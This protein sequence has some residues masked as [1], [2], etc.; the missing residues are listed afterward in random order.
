VLIFRQGL[1]LNNRQWE[2]EAEF[3]VDFD[4]HR[5]NAGR[6]DLESTEN[7]DI[8][9]MGIEGGELEF[10][11]ALRDG[12]ILLWRKDGGLLRELTDAATPA[13]PEA[14]LEKAERQNRG[15]DH[16]DYAHERLLAT[17]LL[18]NILAKHAGLQIG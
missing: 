9:G 13:G 3:A 2:A 5:I 7:M 12:G 6:W 1:N 14:E 8:C 18:A 4:F 11:L 17:G 16:P 15:G 10:D